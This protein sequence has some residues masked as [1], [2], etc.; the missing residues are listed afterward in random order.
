[1]KATRFATITISLDTARYRDRR[2]EERERAIFYLVDRLLG[3]ETV[4]DSELEHFG[5]RVSVRPAV[6]PEILETK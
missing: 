3:G 6:K 1:M 4:A 2:P 5:L